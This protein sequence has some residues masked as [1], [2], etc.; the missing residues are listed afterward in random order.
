M[1]LKLTSE[2]KEAIK[3]L[4]FDLKFMSRMKQ[5][6]RLSIQEY[7]PELLKRENKLRFHESCSWTEEERLQQIEVLK[8][9]LRRSPDAAVLIFGWIR[10]L[11]N[12]SKEER[13]AARDAE[14]WERAK[15]YENYLAAESARIQRESR[16]GRT[17]VPNFF[18]DSEME[19]EK[20][21]EMVRNFYAGKPEPKKKITKQPVGLLLKVESMDWIL[22]RCQWRDELA[23]LGYKPVELEKYSFD[24]YFASRKA[25]KQFIEDNQDLPA[26][27]LMGPAP[28]EYE[29]AA[30]DHS[31]KFFYGSETITRISPRK[32]LVKGHTM[33][34][35]NAHICVGLL[36]RKM[37]ASTS[38]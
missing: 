35:V 8:P 17:S 13:D 7:R 34:R 3:R 6:F 10:A 29:I 23:E 32:Y 31:R 30:G 20:R 14:F 26:A 28:F 15:P 5:T 9:I 24:R 16:R 33:Y 36:T 11:E 38:K 1:T 18:F 12:P 4:G 27:T 25:A 22:L 19:I 21:L 2:E 37:Q